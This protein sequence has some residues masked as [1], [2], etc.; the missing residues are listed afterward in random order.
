MYKESVKFTLLSV[1]SIV[2]IVVVVTDGDVYGI[3]G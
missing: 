3:C 1:L 2:V